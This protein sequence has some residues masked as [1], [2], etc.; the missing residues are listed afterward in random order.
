LL[1]GASMAFIDGLAVGGSV[2]E[3]EARV[4]YDLFWLALLGLAE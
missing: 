1:A 2:T 3:R 4:S